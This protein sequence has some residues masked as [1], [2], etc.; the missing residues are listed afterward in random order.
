[1][2]CPYRRTSSG[3]CVFS[4]RFIVQGP[5]PPGTFGGKV[6][7]ALWLWVDL[8]KSYPVLTGLGVRFGR[9]S[10]GDAPT[11]SGLQPS[12]FDWSYLPR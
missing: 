11:G 2:R 12:L 3:G 4:P 6:F 9:C 1:M 5:L 7:M 8:W 10:V